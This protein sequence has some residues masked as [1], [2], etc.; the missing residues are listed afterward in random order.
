MAG[1][2]TRFY[3]VG[4]DPWTLVTTSA[5]RGSGARS[6]RPRPTS[7]RWAGCS[8]SSPGKRAAPN[9]SG[10]VTRCW[11]TPWHHRRRRLS[12]PER[13]A[14]LALRPGRTPSRPTLPPPTRITTIRY[15]LPPA[16]TVVGTAARAAARGPPVGHRREWG[17]AGGVRGRLRHADPAPV[18]FEA[19]DADGQAGSARFGGRSCVHRSCPGPCVRDGHGRRLIGRKPTALGSG[20]S[21]VRRH[22]SRTG[23]CHGVRSRIGTP[24]VCPPLTPRP[25]RG[26]PQAAATAH[27]ARAGSAGHSPGTRTP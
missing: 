16:W 6:G 24:T 15:P 18:S 17:R 8:W 22:A 7:A 25:H 5:T 3:E 12:G 1:S 21:R 11:W 9:G 10:R 14:Y 19:I 27:P 13:E 26:G 23:S 2:P 20:T 4:L